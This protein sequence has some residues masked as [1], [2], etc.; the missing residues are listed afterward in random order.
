ML[1][2]ILIALAAWVALVLVVGFVLPSKYRVERSTTIHAPAE[3][4]YAQV[5]HLERWQDWAPWNAGKYPGNQWMFGGSAV[6]V[7]AVRSWSGEDVGTG[8]LSLTEADPKTGVAYDMSLED[9]RY[10]LHGRISFSPEGEGTRVTWVDEGDL[11]GGPLV[12]YLRFPLRSRLGGQ[13]E[14]ALAQLKKRVEAGPRPVV[15]TKPEPTPAPAQAA[16]PSREPAP[17]PVAPAEGSPPA[18]P[19]TEGSQVAAPPPAPAGESTQATPG[20][21]AP[22]A[23]PAPVEVPPTPPA[24]EPAPAPSPAPAD[25]QATPTAP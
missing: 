22:T 18:P 15:D 7:G 19:S 5:A 14:E 12:G 23:E 24:S 8:T 4:V 1:K 17:A 21:S 25:A 13:L 6:G 9:G 20:S 11:G 3:A 16:A 2:K 10:L